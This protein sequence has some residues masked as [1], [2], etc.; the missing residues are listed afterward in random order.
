MRKEGS[1]SITGWS[2]RSFPASTRMPRA[3]AVN[4][5][6]FEA[7]P[8]SVCS[9]TGSGSPRRRTPYPFASTTSPSLTIANATPGTSNVSMTSRTCASRSGGAVI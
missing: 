9:S 6:V 3:V 5:F 4:A 8:K 1:S 2:H 7:M